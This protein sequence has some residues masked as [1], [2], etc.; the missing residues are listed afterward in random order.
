MRMHLDKLIALVPLN[1][2]IPSEAL[3]C[4]A[5]IRLVGAVLADN[6]RVARAVNATSTAQETSPAAPTPEHNV[7]EAHDDVVRCRCRRSPA[8]ET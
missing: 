3:G 8:V 6:T 2:L 7:E 5:L 4:N 1:R